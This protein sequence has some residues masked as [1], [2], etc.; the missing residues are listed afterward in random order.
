M[1]STDPI[2]LAVARHARACRLGHDPA[3]RVAT[4]QALSELRLERAIREV[5]DAAPALTDAQ[6]DRLAGLL[7][8]AR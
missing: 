4:K 8:G 3:E 7:R 2:I 1:P 5:V 6:R